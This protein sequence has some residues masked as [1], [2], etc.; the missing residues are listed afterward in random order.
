MIGWAEP[1]AFV[2]QRQPYR[3][4]SWLLRLFTAQEGQLHVISR[5]A[6][7][8]HLYQ[9]YAVALKRQTQGWALQDLEFAG[10]VLRI[11]G[12]AS[13]AALY[14]NELC[15]RLLPHEVP[16]P[17]LF[18]SYFAVLKALALGVSVQPQLRFFESRLLHELG[19]GVD[20]EFDIDHQPI[21]AAA[22]YRFNVDEGFVVSPQGPY[23]GEWIVALGQYDFAQPSVL[24]MAARVY[25]QVLHA[26]LAGRPLHSMALLHQMGVQS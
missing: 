19:V 1:N 7:G 18:G 24:A 20:T 25:Q 6:E 12:P 13:Y 15:A 11:Q 2:L 26:Q 4:Q 16:V 3:E 21:A 9:P 22:Y 14:L 8:V 23:R 5:N 10:K 17:E